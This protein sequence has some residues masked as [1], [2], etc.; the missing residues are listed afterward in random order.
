M[1]RFIVILLIA[2]VLAGCATAAPTATSTPTA[3]PT[4]TAVPTNTA[5]PTP[6]PEPTATNTNTPEPTSTPTETPTATA[7][8]TPQPTS[9]LTSTPTPEPPQ[10]PI[11]YAGT[12]DSVIAIEKPGQLNVLHVTGNA[13]A[14]H[15]AVKAFNAAGESTGLLVNTISAYDGIVPLDF[16][17]DR[18]TTRLQITGQGAWTIEIIPFALSPWWAERIVTIPGT[19]EGTGDAVLFLDGTPDT[20]TV[21]GN[22]AAKHFAVW[23]YH[24]RRDLLINTTGPYKGTVVLNQSTALLEIKAE[25]TWSVT[26]AGK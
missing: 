14:K 17:A 26:I 15:F 22:A 1:K 3:A 7:T 2:A 21:E 12:G 6:T 25:G 11:V 23:G 8:S 16:M 4:A 13:A 10:E 9:T 19:L 18:A 5:E 20:I 24:D